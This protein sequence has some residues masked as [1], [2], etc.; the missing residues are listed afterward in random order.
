MDGE[1]D[2]SFPFE[3]GDLDGFMLDPGV[4]RDVEMR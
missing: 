3:M 2:V 4:D 1:I